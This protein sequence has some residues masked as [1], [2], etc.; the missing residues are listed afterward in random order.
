M[1]NTNTNSVIKFILLNV[2]SMQLAGHLCMKWSEL[3]VY[4]FSIL[5]LIVQYTKKSPKNVGVVYEITNKDTENPQLL[6]SVILLRISAT[7]YMVI[8]QFKS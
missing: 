6:G 2:N 5:L 8:I 1:V 3:Y 7:R 4:M